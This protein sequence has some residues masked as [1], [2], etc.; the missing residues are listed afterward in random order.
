ML[1]WHLVISRDD[2]AH[3]N[4]PHVYTQSKD[5]TGTFVDHIN[6]FWAHLPILKSLSRL[7]EYD[8][9]LSGPSTIHVDADTPTETLSGVPELAE[10]STL[11]WIPCHV[12]SREPVMRALPI[13]SLGL[14]YEQ[15]GYS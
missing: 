7:V 8:S 4:A 12:W 10:I 11:Y 6:P 3:N 9:L 1:Q 14:D 15:I 2:Q 13:P 5:G